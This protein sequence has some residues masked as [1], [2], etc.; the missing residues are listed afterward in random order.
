MWQKLSAEG[1]LQLRSST[2]VE[3]KF[4][5]LEKALSELCIVISRETGNT[6]LSGFERARALRSKPDAGGKSHYEC[7][8]Q[9][10]HYWY[11]CAGA[12]YLFGK[13]FRNLIMR[14]TGHDNVSG[15]DTGEGPFD[16]EADHPIHGRLVAEV[17]CVS[18]GLWPEKMR[19]TRI[20]LSASSAEIRCIFYNS[21]AKPS[22]RPKTEWLIILGVDAKRA[23]RPIHSI[24]A[25]FE[26]AQVGPTSRSTRS[27]A[28]RT[29]D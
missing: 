13:G 29:S 21:E 12:T 19:K 24:A 27:R 26:T 7:I 20:K 10:I 25:P 11:C 6:A 28:K 1:K 8:N 23:I 18:Q 2:S 22:Y 5:S 15:D 4:A 14:P 9:L 3:Q 16:L 17:F